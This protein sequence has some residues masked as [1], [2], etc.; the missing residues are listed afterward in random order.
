MELLVYNNDTVAAHSLYKKC[1][2]TLNE[3]SNRDY[4][5]KDYFNKEI[6]CLDMDTYEKN[7]LHS[8]RPDCR[9]IKRLLNMLCI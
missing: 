5:G 4:P 6:L 8:E 2:S 1:G 9:N 7:V 3:V